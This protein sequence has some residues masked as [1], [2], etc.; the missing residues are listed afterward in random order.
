MKG[1]RVCVYNGDRGDM[2]GC[3]YT[4]VLNCQNV[5]C[6]DEIEYIEADPQHNFF[7]TFSKL[8]TLILFFVDEFSFF[9]DLFI[10]IFKKKKLMKKKSLV[11]KRVIVSGGQQCLQAKCVAPLVPEIVLYVSHT[12]RFYY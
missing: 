7:S 6:L 11:G 4:L 1:A 10:T 2:S 9:H 5:Q 8:L 12:N 3:T